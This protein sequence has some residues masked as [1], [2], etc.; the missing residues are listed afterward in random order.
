MYPTLFKIPF[1]PDWLADVKSYG[2]MIM[3]GFLTGIYLAC[4]RAYRSQ[5]DP[6]IVLNIGFISLVFG[7]LGARLMFVVHYW[8]TRFANQPNPF[9]AAFDIRTGGLEFWGGPLLVVPVCIIYLRYIAK[10]S[11]RWYFDITAPALAWGLAITRLGCFLNGCCWGSVCL[12]PHDAH[13][14]AAAVPW[15]VR[16]PYG[17]PAMN[18]QYKFGQMTLPAELVYVLPSGESLPFPRDFIE[19]AVDDRGET[20][21][22]LEADVKNKHEAAGAALAKFRQSKI[23]IAEAQCR[24]F[25]ISPQQLAELAAAFPSKPVHPSQLYALVN[26]F[27]LYFLLASLFYHRRRHGIILGWFLILY[28]VSRVFLELIRQ[29]N[30][31]DVGGVTISQAISVG[32]LILG[33]LWL[34]VMYRM[35]PPMSP[36]AVPFEPPPDEVPQAR[37]ATKTK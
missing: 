29:D 35:L 24:K 1:L 3:I 10:V 7:I 37:P 8:H 23:G 33:I 18:Q 28:S 32:T 4:R 17:S 11:T 5:A 12:D 22:K 9:A 20:L 19:A 21:R 6:D 36:R 26:G 27:L 34:W 25:G 13:R 14:Q 2:V 16:F 31:L 15:A 30:P